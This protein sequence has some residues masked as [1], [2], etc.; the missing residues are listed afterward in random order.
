MYEICATDMEFEQCKP[1]KERIRLV[2]PYTVI[3]YII[4][5]SGT[6]N[7]QKVTKGSA[8]VSSMNSYMD[9][10]PDRKDPWSYIYIRLSGE[11]IEKH[12]V[13]W[14]LRTVQVLFLLPN[15]L[16][17]KIFFHFLGQSVHWKIV[18]AEKLLLMHFLC[19]I[20]KHT[21][22]QIMSEC[23]NVMCS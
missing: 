23:R 19:C 4:S 22:N 14:G 2:V 8:F 3:H 7:G 13:M 15:I 16:N 10:Y 21:M 11:G 12:L 6:I 5:G 17:L 20:R 9:Y 1:H 18:T